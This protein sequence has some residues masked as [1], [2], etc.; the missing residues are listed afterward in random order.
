MVNI[1]II[2]P[3]HEIHTELLPDVSNTWKA[4][5]VLNATVERGGENLDKI[6]L[7]I[8][9]QLLESKTSLPLQTGEHIKLLVKT[10]G[11]T[12]LLS[13]ITPPTTAQI[14]ATHLRPFINAQPD[15]RPVIELVIK[16]LTE[17]RA[18]ASTKPLL[19]QLLQLIPNPEQLSQ[20]QTLKQLIQNSGVLLEPNLAKHPEPLTSDFKARLQQLENV[21][22]TVSPVAGQTSNHEQ[23]IRF[24]QNYLRDPQLPILRLAQELGALISPTDMRQLISAI[25][26]HKIDAPLTTAIMQ[27][28]SHVQKNHGTAVLE[29]LLK[30]INDQNT[31]AE[32]KAAVTQSIA[33]ISQQQLL[34]MLRDADS[35]LLLLFGLP[36]RLD[37][38]THWINFRIE[39]EKESA[40]EKQSSWQVTLNFD[41]STLGP[42]QASLHLKGK[43]LS[44]TFRADQNSTL[45]KIRNYL[46]LLERALNK[47]GID[48]IKLEAIAGTINTAQAV[49]SNVHL[50]DEQ[51]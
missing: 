14:A 37:N 17:N 23:A 27:L 20:P 28:F 50:L 8:G 36:L 48:V 49:M 7:R 45:E 11:T 10:L 2:P 42:L 24:I 1:P 21:L 40:Q 22:R 30:L 35:A 47:A 29:Q 43:Q 25:E 32:L 12:P 3:V 41:I 15:W 46:P 33:H 39:K 4:G 18:P 16:M 44:T 51:A 31:T 9:H 34:P 13:I 38:Q 19:Q 26:L 5:Q 6:L